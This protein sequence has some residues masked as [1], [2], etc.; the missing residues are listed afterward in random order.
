M[1]THGLVWMKMKTGGLRIVVAIS[2]VVISMAVM[3]WTLVTDWE[4]L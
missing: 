2:M 3:G 4:R 1:R